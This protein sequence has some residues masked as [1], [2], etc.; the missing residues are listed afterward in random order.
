MTQL[1]RSTLYGKPWKQTYSTTTKR[2]ANNSVPLHDII[3]FFV[4]L[5]I[6]P[7]QQQEHTTKIYV[8]R[9]IR[10]L[11]FSFLL[12]YSRYQVTTTEKKYISIY[13]ASNIL[14]G[15]SSM[16]WLRHQRALWNTVCCMIW[17]QTSLFV[18]RIN[19]NNE[20]FK[21]E[22]EELTMLPSSYLR[23]SG[24]SSGLNRLDWVFR[25]WVTPQKSETR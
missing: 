3:F 20:Y 22:E 13:F 25:C 6:V 4:C 18:E 16:G 2:K 11:F 7:I 19:Y 23:E 14:R 8:D 5:V 12:K 10:N 15:D 24:L 1:Q 21:K 9:Y 17:F